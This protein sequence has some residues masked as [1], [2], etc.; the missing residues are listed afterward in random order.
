MRLWSQIAPSHHLSVVQETGKATQLQVALKLLL[1]GA[2]I[3]LLFNRLYG[4]ILIEFVLDE[5]VLAGILV[6]DP[7]V[8]LVFVHC[9]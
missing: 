8:F 4:T 3:N 9:Q 6:L 2:V 1:L 7:L 5:S